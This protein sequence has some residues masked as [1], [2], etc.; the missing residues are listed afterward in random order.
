MDSELNSTLTRIK[1]SSSDLLKT[2]Y[3]SS[4]P[5]EMAPPT[6]FWKPYTDEKLAIGL[7]A[8]LVMWE[9]SGKKIVPNEFQVTTTIA[10]MSGQ[11][12]LDTGMAVEHRR[13]SDARS[14]GRA[15]EF[16]SGSVRIREP[17]KDVAVHSERSANLNSAVPACITTETRPNVTFLLIR[18]VTSLENGWV[19]GLI[20]LLL[21][22]R[23]VRNSSPASS[24]SMYGTQRSCSTAV[25]L[26]TATVREGDGLLPFPLVTS[27]QRRSKEGSPSSLFHHDEHFFH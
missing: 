4:I 13:D 15:R 11:K 12:D 23:T 3:G 27:F 5:A 2:L 21:K 25:P 16:C 22:L 6:S 10:L 14:F 9:A 1:N 7:C 19:R 17:F 8:C 26:L 20:G 24:L 18:L